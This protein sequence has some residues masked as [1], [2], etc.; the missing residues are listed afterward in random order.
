MASKVAA[1]QRACQV[2]IPVVIAPARDGDIL[3]KISTGEDAGTLFL[4]AG[5]ALASRKY[6][7][8][9][10]L[11]MRGTVVVDD[12]AVKA[13]TVSKRSLLPIGIVESRGE[14]RSGDAISV[15]T[16]DGRELARGLARYDSRDVQKLCGVRSE[17][18]EQRLGFYRGDEIIH[19]DD[20]VVL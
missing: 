20:L 18:I 11:K 2:G 6:W 12:G 19:R 15:V 8:A 13:L 17:E 16:R 3:R 9:Y 10:T 4:P 1:A 7:I 5:A 14:F